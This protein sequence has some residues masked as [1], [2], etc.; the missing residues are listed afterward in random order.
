MIDEGLIFLTQTLIFIIY[1]VY[2]DDDVYLQALAYLS[3]EH[4]F[5]RK[6]NRVIN[7]CVVHQ[8][9]YQ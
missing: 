5:C 8:T 3:I 4:S 1:R 7:I 9:R 2:K 6:T